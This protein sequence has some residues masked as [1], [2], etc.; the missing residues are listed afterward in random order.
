MHMKFTTT[1]FVSENS[2][3]PVVIDWSGAITDKTG[4]D[5]NIEK[6]LEWVKTYPRKADVHVYLGKIKQRQVG[7]RLQGSLQ[8]MGCKVTT[9]H[10][11]TAVRMS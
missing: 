10:Y 4:S 7:R 2:T 6:M 8:A 11:Q 9:K 3:S 5:E 1:T